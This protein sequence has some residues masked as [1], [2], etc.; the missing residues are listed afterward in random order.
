ME[1]KTCVVT[2]A[3]S[4][5]GE[6]TALGLAKLGARVVV[7]GR[8]PQRAK[9]SV[10]RI[11]RESG[12]DR[13]DSLLGDLASLDSIRH[14]ADDVLEACPHIDVLVNNAGIV[15]LR[16]E[17]TV[18]GFEAMFGV[19]H[20]GPFLLTNLLLERIEHSAPARIVNVASE[21]HR[22]G[23]IDLGDLQSE[24]SFGSMKTYG[25]SKA[26][27]ILFTVELAKRLAGTGVTAN[28]VHPGGV[29]TRL[30]ANSGW[31]GKVAMKLVSPFLLS[32]ARGA[33]TS[34][35]VATSPE[36]D[37]VTGRY[38]AKSRE[39][40]PAAAARDPETAKRLWA[41]SAELTGSPREQD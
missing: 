33:E 1:G 5:I 39:R 38:F 10:E 24:K 23:S 30:G 3:T 13:V 31:L 34:L 4:G 26:A 16:R 20:L 8:D 21:A 15:T 22:F 12:S 28:C 40:T 25:R 32:P 27:N 19:N 18:D 11:R 9:H 41:I 14:L 7:I 36:V 2:G 35:Y 37:G 29:A 6:E 17:T